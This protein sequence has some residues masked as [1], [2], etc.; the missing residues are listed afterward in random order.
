MVLAWR[1]WIWTTTKPDFLHERYQSRFE[2]YWSVDYI[3][4]LLLF[5]KPRTLVI[6]KWKKYRMK[7]ASTK[8][9]ARNR[10]L[11][12]A[13]CALEQAPKYSFIVAFF[14]LV[15]SRRFVSHAFITSIRLTINRPVLLSCSSIPWRVRE[16]GS[17][18]L[19]PLGADS[20]AV[21][22]SI[23]SSL[24]LYLFLPSSR[25]PS[26]LDVLYGPQQRIFE[27]PWRS[28]RR[29]RGSATCAWSSFDEGSMLSLLLPAV[30]LVNRVQ[31]G[32]HAARI[33]LQH[34][35]QYSVRVAFAVVIVSEYNVFV[36]ANWLLF[37][38]FPRDE[39]FSSEICRAF[40]DDVCLT[41]S[42]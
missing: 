26:L 25:F 5:I 1:W 12:C 27:R 16:F 23:F 42:V 31:V 19:T 22:L 40:S 39:Q 17:F 6:Q 37:F 38:L 14:S 20:S 2:A 28:R 7:C 32:I 33:Q 36:A 29:R 3:V 15:C 10:H 21:S 13:D 18:S 35:R 24:L 4:H 34:R 41:D 9:M 8:R 30:S 11:I